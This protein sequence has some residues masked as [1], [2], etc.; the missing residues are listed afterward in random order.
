MKIDYVWNINM[1]LSIFY[2]Y[3]KNTYNI[4]EKKN[5]HQKQL[6]IVWN[7]MI[8]CKY[9]K[10]IHVILKYMSFFINL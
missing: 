4:G 7:I 1:F 8:Q 10:N 6:I 3:E 2:S 9:V 5:R